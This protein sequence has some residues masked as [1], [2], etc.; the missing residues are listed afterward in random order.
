MAAI[1]ELLTTTEQEPQGR[2]AF[3][4]LEGLD[5]SGKTTQVKLMEQ[6]FV[7]LGKPVK[8][9]RFP[10]RT[11]LIGQMIDGYLRSNVEMDDH[12]IHLLFSANRWEAAGNIKALLA[13]GVN[14]ISDRYFHSGVVYSAAKGN[15]A[16]GM[17]WARAPEDLGDGSGEKEVVVLDAG[18][19][20]EG[21]AEAIWETIRG[22][23]E[24]VERGERGELKN[25]V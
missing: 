17:G 2:G 8:T 18:D 14:V 3:I 22:R 4:V 13:R 7:E 12:A 24:E 19:N 1:N 20:V 9:V 23:V 10:D 15:P 5:R 25:V 6:R 16:L 21:V 11:T